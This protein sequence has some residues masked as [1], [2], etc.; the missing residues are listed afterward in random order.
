MEFVLIEPQGRCE[1]CYGKSNVL[2][3]A[4]LNCK[5]SFYMGKYELTQGQWKKVMGNNP[6]RFQLMSV[7]GDNAS[8]MGAMLF[9]AYPVDSVDIADVEGFLKKLNEVDDKNKPLDKPYRLPTEQE[10]VF[11]AQGGRDNQYAFSQKQLGQYAWFAHNSGGSTHPVGLKKPNVY[12]LYDMLGN[13]FEWTC[14]AYSSDTY[15]PVDQ[16]C[17]SYRNR[18][19]CGGS[20]SYPYHYI[21]SNFRMTTSYSGFRVVLPH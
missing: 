19:I 4:R 5:G 20:Y 1:D 9:D 12:G 7:V 3:C 21:N 17:N 2:Q 10:W 8:K 14:S 6:S 15:N 11:A 13:V 16:G 18:V